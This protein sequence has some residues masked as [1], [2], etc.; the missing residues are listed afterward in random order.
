MG[1]IILLVLLLLAAGVFTLNKTDR[2]SRAIAKAEGF[3][4]HGSLPQ[5]ANNPGDLKLGDQGL[6]TIN[7][8]TVYK[9]AVDGWLHLNKEVI[10]ILSGKSKYYTPD[11]TISELAEVWTGGDA[12]DSWAATVA[13][14]LGV[15]IDTKIKDV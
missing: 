9:S 7:G 12:S 5:R 10:L 2:I 11:M 14:S 4:V 3:F 6:G 13:E 15:S 1:A 8:K